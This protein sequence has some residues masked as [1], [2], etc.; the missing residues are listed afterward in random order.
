MIPNYASKLYM[1]RPLRITVPDLPFHVLDRGNNRQ[2]VFRE[3]QDFVYFLKLLKKYKK[4]LKFKLY[5]FCLMPNHIHLMI[6]PTVEGSLSKIMMRLT[7]A[8]S[9]FFNKKYQGVGHVWQGRYKS[10]LIDKENYFIYC[11]L[12]NELNPVRAGLATRPENWRWSSYR[13][14]AF[15]EIN[16]LTEGLIDVDP[17]YLNLGPESR[18]RQKK[19]RENV[20]EVVKEEAFLKNIRE[21]LDGGIFGRSSFIQEMKEKFKIKSLRPRGRPRREGK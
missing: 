14:Y 19:Y 5:R 18:E 16:P 2:V 21:E 8:Y 4:E 1:A 7:L 15:G 12:Y 9:S 10:S 6:E 3:E 17:Y 20:E 13:F 11:G